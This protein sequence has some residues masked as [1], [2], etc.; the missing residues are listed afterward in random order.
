MFVINLINEVVIKK[1]VKKYL[2]GKKLVEKFFDNNVEIY[3]TCLVV[4]KLLIAVF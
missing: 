3:I 4:K 2:I 1:G